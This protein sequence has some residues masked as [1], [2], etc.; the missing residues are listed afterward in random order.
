MRRVWVRVKVSASARVRVGVR[1][2]RGALGALDAFFLGVDAALV[3]VG[4]TLAGQLRATAF[5]AV[6]ARPAQRAVGFLGL[7]LV[8]AGLTRR[9]LGHARIGRVAAGRARLGL[10]RARI[11]REASHALVALFLIADAALV[12]VGATLAGQLR[13]TACGAVLARPAQRALGFLGLVLILAGLARLALGHARTGRV[14]AGRAR[15]GL[16]RARSAREASR[17]IAAFLGGGE[18]GGVAVGAGGAERR[19]SGARLAEFTRLAR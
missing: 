13:A 12:A 4:A 3:A 5:G 16:G 11:A 9:A 8:L 7:V 1:G 18:V 15:L 6:L 2:A 14:A 17:A 10:N 19:L